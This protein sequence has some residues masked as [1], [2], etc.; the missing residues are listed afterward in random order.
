MILQRSEYREEKSKKMSGASK[1]TSNMPAYLKRL[2]RLRE[3]KRRGLPG[4]LYRRRKN[5]LLRSLKRDWPGAYVLT[6]HDEL[7]FIPAPLDSRGQHLMFYGFDIP[8]PV[9][10]FAPEGANVIDV[11]ANL[12]EWS[13]PLAKAVGAT[14]RVICCEPNPYIA[15]ALAATLHINNLSQAQVFQI[16]I[17]AADGEGR[18]AIDAEDSGLS[19]L[20]ETGVPVPLRSLDSIVANIGLKRLDLLK[21]DVEG[22]E[23]SVFEGAVTTINKMQPAVIFESG[24]E[25]PADRD[26]IGRR[27]NE[28][29]YDVIAVL[30]HYGALPCTLADYCLARGPC[31]GS[32]ARNLLA[33]PRAAPLSDVLNL[34][35]DYPR[36]RD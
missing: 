14:G 23:A 4:F 27:L 36:R 6:D 3:D 17:S 32:E 21:V 24:H 33:L 28:M 16:A 25:A 34:L 8:E 22:H 11:G 9:L 15:S 29:G 5:T 19:R 18:L 31:A 20:A 12:G 13:V 7:A 26:H 2:Y 30:H 35:S 10:C 1:S